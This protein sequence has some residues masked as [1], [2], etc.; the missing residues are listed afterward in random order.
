[1]PVIVSQVVL[2]RRHSSLITTMV[3]QGDH[4]NP[5]RQQGLP[6][7][8]AVGIAVELRD[9]LEG[10]LGVMVIAQEPPSDAEYHRPV[11]RHDSGGGG[12]IGRSATR[13]EPLEQLAVR[14]TGGA[15]AFKERAD[16][17]DQRRR[18]HVCHAP[19]PL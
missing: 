18:C 16:L 11:A 1:M 14:D 3:N 4:A 2:K 12:L 10:V 8:T 6:R 7:A 9:R 13:R 19:W 5:K 15:A 17:P